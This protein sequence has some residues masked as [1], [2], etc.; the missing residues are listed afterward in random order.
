MATSA[1]SKLVL[2]LLVR[3]KA[4]MQIIHQ[5]PSLTPMFTAALMLSLLISPQGRAAWE[6]EA[7]WKCQCLCGEGGKT[8]VVDE[9]KYSPFSLYVNYITSVV[10]TD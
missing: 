4:V 9:A 6:D 2:M 10:D 1:V 5:H 3:L 7:V 8:F